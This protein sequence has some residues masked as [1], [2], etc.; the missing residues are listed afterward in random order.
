[1]KKIIRKIYKMIGSVALSVAVLSIAELNTF[2][3]LI[4]HQP[5]IPKRLR[6]KVGLMPGEQ[7]ES[8]DV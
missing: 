7:N 1:M 2:C 6:E 8:I 4:I 5:D 3:I